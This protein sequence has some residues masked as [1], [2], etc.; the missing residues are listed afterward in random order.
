MQ[1]SCKEDTLDQ[2]LYSS[3]S[4][5]F[6]WL[7]IAVCAYFEKWLQIL[8]QNKHNIFLQPFFFFSSLNLNGFQYSSLFI[9][10]S[11][12]H[13][14]CHLWKRKRANE[15]LWIQKANW[16]YSIYQPR[17]ISTCIIVT[18]KQQQPLLPSPPPSLPSPNH[19]PHSQPPS[20]PPTYA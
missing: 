15:Y 16:H 17:Y 5:I 14:K 6:L 11:Q 2:S 13:I 3:V 20:P 9:T 8:M 1:R 19:P 7:S 18:L 4:E 10:L 12:S